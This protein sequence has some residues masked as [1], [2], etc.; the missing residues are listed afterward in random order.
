MEHRRYR[1]LITLRTS[2]PLGTWFGREL[3]TPKFTPELDT[4]RHSW[5]VLED[6]LKECTDMV[7]DVVR[8]SCSD[9]ALLRVLIRLLCQ[10]MPVVHNSVLY[11]TRVIFWN[12]HILGI[13]PK[14]KCSYITLVPDRPELS[15][16]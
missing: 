1:P 2:L 5:E 16:F 12:R 11:N 3:L 14:V 6:L 4:T 10:G 13:R 9:I 8:L 7:V 15:T